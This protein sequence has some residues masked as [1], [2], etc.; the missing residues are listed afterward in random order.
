MPYIKREQRDQIDKH[1]ETLALAAKMIEGFEANRGGILNYIIT[2]LAVD[3]CG[4][5]SYS[6]LSLMRSA[7]EDAS[8]EWYRRKM[9]GYE[10]A[11]CLEN[12]EAY[13][14]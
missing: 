1:I 2:R 13:E 9:S 6:N 8:A 12:G 14:L 4:K 3:F 10:D 5:D 7:M 11:K